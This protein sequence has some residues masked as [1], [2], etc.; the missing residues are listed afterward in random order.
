M[1]KAKT[2]IERLRG[3]LDEA[4]RLT[5]PNYAFDEAR[6]VLGVLTET[7]DALSGDRLELEKF[8]RAKYLA[9][10]PQA[11]TPDQRAE[12][13]LGKWLVENPGWTHEWVDDEDVDFRLHLT[14]RPG[15]SPRRRMGYQGY[16]P[17]KAEAILDALRKAGCKDV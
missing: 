2:P 11:E 7:L 9:D 5:R 1:E 12:R 14:H 6:A 16:G 3:A 13:L 17:T 4:E 10:C 8:R 15:Q